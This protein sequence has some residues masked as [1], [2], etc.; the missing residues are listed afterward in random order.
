MDHAYAAQAA[1]ARVEQEIGERIVRFVDGHAVQID[2]GLYRPVAP[3]QLHEHVGPK[4]AAAPFNLGGTLAVPVTNWFYLMA[5]CDFDEDGTPS[6][7]FT[8]SDTEGTI[9]ENP[10]E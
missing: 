6:R 5:E 10:G 7:Y 1:I 8:L 9:T 4:A 2:D 3:S